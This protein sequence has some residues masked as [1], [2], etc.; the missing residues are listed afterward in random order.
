MGRGLDSCLLLD[1][2]VSSWQGL[3]GILILTC[4]GWDYIMAHTLIT[5][6]QN[7]WCKISVYTILILY[8]YHGP[9][10]W[11]FSRSWA[12]RWEKGRVLLGRFCSWFSGQ[13]NSNRRRV[14]NKLNH[15]HPHPV[16]S[17]DIISTVILRWDWNSTIN[18]RSRACAPGLD[19]LSCLNSNPH[20][21]K[22]NE[23]HLSNILLY[24][25]F[26]TDPACIERERER[27]RQTMVVTS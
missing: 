7:E 18:N 21:K 15:P 14:W 24:F 11:T 12:W 19:S 23:H 10:F 25:L 3:S 9:K 20:P 13:Q 1:M 26:S 4:S 6:Q 2:F 16:M 27:E 17:E 8:S 22:R 5:I